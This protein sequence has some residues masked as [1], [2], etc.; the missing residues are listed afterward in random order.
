M[1]SNVA[2]AI[3]V[4]AAVTAVAAWLRLDDLGRPGRKVFDEI[5]YASDGCWY[6]GI[7]YQD[8]GLDQDVERSWVHPPLGKVLIAAGI[9]AFGNRPF[10]WRVSAA[11]AGTLTVALAGV[12]AFLLFGSWIWAGVG[13]LLVGSEHLLF[14]QSRISMLDVFLAMFV[15]AGFMFL[16]WDRVR[17]DRERHDEVVEHTPAVD[18][19]DPWLDAPPEEHTEPVR[20]FRPRPLRLLAGASMGA[21]TAVKWSGL[22]ALAGAV[23]LSLWWESRRGRRPGVSRLPARLGS[24]IVALGFSAL[25]VYVASWAPWLPDRGGDLAELASHHVDMAEYHRELDT[26]NDD[27]EPAHPYM[28]RAWEWP[29]MLRPVAYHWEGDAATGQE[30]LA[31]GNPVIVWGGF[32]VLPFV[33]AGAVRRR[34]WR[35]SAIAVPILV[36][37]LPWLAVTRPLF[38]FY[39]TPVTPFLALALTAAARSVSAMKLGTRRLVAPAA[40]IVVLGVL[41]FAFFWPVLTANTLSLDDWRARIWFSSWV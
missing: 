2:K 12:L 24:A 8:C 17:R 20:A 26:V 37:Y 7:D 16:V 41:A 3:V 18:G 23:L 28:S 9:D 40:L 27:G 1:R 5:Y 22:F 13:A 19:E 33:V 35:G 10:G 15:V 39:L 4:V 32:L 34:D 14:V 36:Q 11:L 21:A 29:L 31:I 38:L 6:S 25:V 30:I